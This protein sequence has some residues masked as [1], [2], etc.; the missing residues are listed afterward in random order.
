MDIEKLLPDLIARF[1]E[2][3]TRLERLVCALISSP[4]AQ[5]EAQTELQKGYAGAIVERAREFEKEMDEVDPEEIADQPAIGVR[6]VELPCG[7]MTVST[8]G[9][10]QFTDMNALSCAITYALEETAWR[11]GGFTTEDKLAV[12]IVSQILKLKSRP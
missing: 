2:K 1:P 8:D 10:I 3:V 5:W 6:Q 4:R 11:G 12:R 7:R 9:M